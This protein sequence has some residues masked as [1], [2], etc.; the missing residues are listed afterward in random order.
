MIDM[1]RRMPNRRQR[2]KM[3]KASRK[4]TLKTKPKGLKR[5]E[6]D[7]LLITGTFKGLYPNRGYM[8][9]FEPMRKRITKA[10]EA[11]HFRNVTVTSMSQR[12]V[13]KLKFDP[14][15]KTK[16]EKTK[17]KEQIIKKSR[18]KK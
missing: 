12:K 11:L 18:Q 17:I 6:K 13:G 5:G 3:K 14:K 15:K 16:A 9:K 2:R 8:G 4:V 7:I 10:L 1:Q